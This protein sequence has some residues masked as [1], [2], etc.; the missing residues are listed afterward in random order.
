LLDREFCK[1]GLEEL[2]IM[3]RKFPLTREE[4]VELE[5]SGNNTRQRSTGRWRRYTVEAKKVG[6]RT[7]RSRRY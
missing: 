5:R 3:M 1:P 6:K 2:S 4:A 7:A